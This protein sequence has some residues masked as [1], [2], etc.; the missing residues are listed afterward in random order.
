MLT[1]LAILPLA[2]G[3]HVAI[4][5]CE[6]VSAWMRDLSGMTERRISCTAELAP[7]VVFVATP[8]N[9][10][11]R[12]KE[13]VANALNARWKVVDGG[14]LGRMV[15]DSKDLN[16]PDLYRDATDA[17]PHGIPPESTIALDT[18]HNDVLARVLDNGDLD[19]PGTLEFWGGN[20][21]EA[22]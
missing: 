20:I 18:S 6:T 2:A 4:F 13:A 16:L 9:D 1:F 14:D 11:A 21:G 22:I 5:R 15:M 8:D 12:V 3:N 17:F 7:Q 19:Q 10:P